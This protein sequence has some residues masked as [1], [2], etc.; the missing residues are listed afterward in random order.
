M[1][2]DWIS[3]QIKKREFEKKR[4]GDWIE[5]SAQLNLGE[6]ECVTLVNGFVS[7]SA[8]VLQVWPNIVKNRCQSGFSLPFIRVAYGICKGNGLLSSTRIKPWT[9]INRQRFLPYQGI[10][11]RNL[12]TCIKALSLTPF[13]NRFS[14][15]A[16]KF[17]A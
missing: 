5:F 14:A 11:Y 2:K 1:K 7:L 3:R 6:L 17:V 10:K 15:V 8:T 13:S 9:K 16:Y 12:A 4:E